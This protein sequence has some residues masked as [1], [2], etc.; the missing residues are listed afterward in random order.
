MTGPRLRLGGHFARR[1]SAG[2]V[3]SVT[4]MLMRDRQ[5]APTQAALFHGAVAVARDTPFAERP[6]DPTPAGY[7][8]ALVD[9][10]GPPQR[11]A[12]RRRLAYMR[13]LFAFGRVDPSGKDVL[14]AG[15]GFGLGLLAAA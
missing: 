5:E 15:S 8:G 10:D 11:E 14:E 9:R 3:V 4:A 13:D 6:G 12:E 2:R 1:A 7:Y